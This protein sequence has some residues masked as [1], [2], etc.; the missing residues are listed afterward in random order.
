VPDDRREKPARPMPWTTNWRLELT[1]VSEA[2]KPQLAQKRLKFAS[3]ANAWARQAKKAREQSAAGKQPSGPFPEA[4]IVLF[5]SGFVNDTV[6]LREVSVKSNFG[7]FALLVFGEGDHGEAF[8]P[9]FAFV[10]KRIGGAEDFFY[11]R[12]M[13]FWNFDLAD[14][15]RGD[16]EVPTVRGFDRLDH[17]LP[18]ERKVVSKDGRIVPGHESD[19]AFAEKD[20]RFDELQRSV[21]G[22][23]FVFTVEEGIDLDFAEADEALFAGGLGLVEEFELAIGFLRLDRVGPLGKIDG[24]RASEEISGRA[25]GDERQ[26]NRDGERHEEL[27]QDRF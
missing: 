6:F 12:P 18:D 19:L 16:F 3:A 1:N 13:A 4:K 23:A 7:T 14:T 27:L 2:F 22:G 9:A 17:A 15:H 21:G 8:E 10:E 11:F 20:A 24:E 26:D 25:D 5:R